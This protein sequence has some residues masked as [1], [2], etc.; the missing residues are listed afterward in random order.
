MALDELYPTTLTQRPPIT[1]Q[2]LSGMKVRLENNLK[3]VVASLQ[4]QEQ[5]KSV[6]HVNSMLQRQVV[7]LRQ[8]LIVAEQQPE[9][10]RAIIEAKKSLVELEYQL[11]QMRLHCESA[12][13]ES[14]V[15]SGI[16]KSALKKRFEYEGEL[17]VAPKKASKTASRVR[18]L[19][20]K[21]EP[22]INAKE[23]TTLQ[24]Q[25]IEKKLPGT[26]ALSIYHLF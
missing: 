12:R 4:L 8:Q 22:G 23:L 9:H 7:E 3:L 2:E 15:L 6:Q 10:F 11:P 18:K 26:G 1:T 24:L 16:L 5:L 14:D 19:E 13:T 21:L 25:E 17:E 20:L